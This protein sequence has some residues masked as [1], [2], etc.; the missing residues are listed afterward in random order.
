MNSFRVMT[1]NIHSCRGTDGE[2]SPERIAEV[3]EN[4]QPDIVALQEVDVFRTSSGAIDQA[5]E[6]ANYLKMHHHF[7]SC[8]E[9]QEG[10]YGNAILSRFPIQIIKQE[11]FNVPD[12]KI[13][14]YCNPFFGYQPEPRGILC[15]SIEVHSRKINFFNTHFELFKFLRSDQIKALISSDWLTAD[16]LQEPVVLCCDLNDT[17][18]SEAYKMLKNIFNDS[19]RELKYRKPKKTFP[20]FFPVLELDHIFIN[21]YLK[22]KNF[23]VVSNSLT[24]KASDHLPLIADLEFKTQKDI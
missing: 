1:Y 9:V 11:V 13:P 14:W 23:S 22:V 21:N 19:Q 15:A 12:K 3:I 20:S 18:R 16:L 6:I 5:H 2:F 24:R 4:C 7:F 10:Q 8:M 17:I